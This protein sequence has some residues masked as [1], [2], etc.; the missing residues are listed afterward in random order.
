MQV[1][2]ARGKP[3]PQPV[4]LTRQ[5]MKQ[6]L[7]FTTIVDNE[8]SMANVSRMARSAGWHVETDKKEDGF[9][10]V[11]TPGGLDA[12]LMQ[13]AQTRTQSEATATAK[14]P[15]VLFLASD[16]I[17]QG[18]DTLGQVLMRALI[19]T[20]QEVEPRPDV[21]VFMNNGVRLATEGSP[22]ADDLRLLEE[23]GIELLVCGTCLDFFGLTDK[24]VVGTISNMYTI[25]ETLLNASNVV[26]L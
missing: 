20:L 22:V 10:L 21:I 13:A 15:L 3:C 19:S 2:D 16:V 11:I 24:L 18:D 12:T 25:A 4:V 5:A 23:A 9:H 17:G 1:V 6:G 26:R 8:V 7:P 14:E